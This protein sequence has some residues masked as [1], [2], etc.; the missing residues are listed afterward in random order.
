MQ[1]IK[2][3][4]IFS[5]NKELPATLSTRLLGKPTLLW[6]NN[7]NEISID[8]ERVHPR[9]SCY[10]HHEGVK[11][12]NYEL[13]FNQL[14]LRPRPVGL[15]KKPIRL[16]KPIDLPWKLTTNHLLSFSVDSFHQNTSKG[17]EEKPFPLL[18]LDH[19]HTVLHPPSK[20]QPRCPLVTNGSEDNQR[21]ILHK[22]SL[23]GNRNK[24]KDSSSF[25]SF[26]VPVPSDPVPC[27]VALFYF[28]LSKGGCNLCRL[29]GSSLSFLRKRSTR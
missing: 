3:W 1:R 15:E 20:K 9:Q 13:P 6:G 29:S 5:T 10:S 21:D 27:W 11:L 19:N 18:T 26:V 8:G 7:S 16:L 12:T 23:L 17:W 22:D 14:S 25:Y 24:K 4:Q 2:S 28:L